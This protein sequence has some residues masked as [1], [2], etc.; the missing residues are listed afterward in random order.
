MSHNSERS[1]D[2]CLEVGIAILPNMSL[3]LGYLPAS[4]G[5]EG[6]DRHSLSMIMSKI[7]LALLCF[8]PMMDSNMASDGETKAF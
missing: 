6:D 1:E 8:E 4:S 2:P 3:G 7:S 5:V